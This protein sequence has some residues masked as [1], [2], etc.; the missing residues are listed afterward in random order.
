[1]YHVHGIYLIIHF[2]MDITR[3]SVPAF[4]LNRFNIDFRPACS[5]LSPVR[6]SSPLKTENPQALWK[7]CST[8]KSFLLISRQ[9][10]P[11][12]RLWC[13]HSPF[14]HAELWRPWLYL[15]DYL[16]IDTGMLLWGLKAISSP[17]WT[18][19]FSSA[20]LMCQCSNIL[21]IAWSLSY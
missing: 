20:P 17:D 7:T 10:L 12:F 4:C 3:L 18:S 9:N 2:G 16:L 21:T 14:Y 6:S 5:A 8:W 1:M 13:Y 15:P 19:P 11:W